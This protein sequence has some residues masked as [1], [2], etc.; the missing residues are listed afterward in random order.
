MYHAIFLD[1]LDYYTESN[2]YV[3]KMDERISIESKIVAI[4]PEFISKKYFKSERSK[5]IAIGDGENEIEMIKYAGLGVSMGNA[6][7]EVSYE[8]TIIQL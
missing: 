3:E 1:V 6:I 7:E 5:F 4:K 8:G 2:W